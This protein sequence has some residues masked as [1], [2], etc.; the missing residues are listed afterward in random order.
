MPL[1]LA[2]AVGSAVAVTL[3]LTLVVMS[4]AAHVVSSRPADHVTTLGLALGAAGIV[5]GLATL[6]VF[7]FTR[8][9]RPA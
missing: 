9:G 5:V 6:L 7:A 1:V 8:A 2:L 4:T 3:G